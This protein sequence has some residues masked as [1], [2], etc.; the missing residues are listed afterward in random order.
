M[1]YIIIMVKNLFTLIIYFII[2]ITMSAYAADIVYPKLNVVRINSEKTFFI[3]SETSGNPLT[4]NGE[5]V[6]IHKSGGFYHVVNLNI[7]KNVFVI[8]NGNPKDKKTYTIIR[9]NVKYVSKGANYTS[10]DT[11][12]VYAT[13]ADNVPLR[14]YPNDDGHNRLQHFQKGVLL[15]VIGEQ[16]SYYKVKLARDDYAWIEKKYLSKVTF[17]DYAPASIQSYDYEENSEYKRFAIKLDKKVPF[18]LSENRIFNVIEQKY[19]P[20][21]KG[22]DLTL[23]NVKDLPENKYEL[24]IVNDSYLFGYSAEYSDS[25][26]LIIT[27]KKQ[28]KISKSY[29]LKG[30]NITLDPGH[31]G[32]EYGAIGCLGNKEKDINLAIA[33]KTKEALEKAG[34]NVFITRSDDSEVSLHDRVRYSQEKNSDVFISIHSNALPDSL[35]DSKR[36]GTSV[37]YFYPQSNNLARIIQKTL[38]QNLGLN[39]DKVRNESFAVIRNT[40]SLS[41]LIEVGYM[42]VPEDNAKLIDPEFQAKAANAIVRG[43]EKYFSE[44]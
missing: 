43:L 44:I 2:G 14:A 12:I 8:D 4:I 16:G 19:E 38:T 35:A 37:Y 18:I 42:I 36:S 26:E 17:D 11:P 22:L 24:H 23:Y 15:Y 29:P 10:F 28:P 5:K 31:G 9:P 6:N 34:A 27:I 30:L 21:T 25:N 41:I 32:S 1:L 33:L 39:N 3:G 13:A 20:F 7:G 40:E